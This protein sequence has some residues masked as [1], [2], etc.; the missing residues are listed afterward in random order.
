MQGV[1]GDVKQKEGAGCF[2]LRRINFQETKTGMRDQ[3]QA[4]KKKIRWRGSM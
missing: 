2:I 3:D 1:E 4:G